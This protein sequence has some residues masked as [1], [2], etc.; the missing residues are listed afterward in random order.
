MASLD[1]IIVLMM[2]NNS[3]DRMLGALFAERADGGGIRGTARNHWN[4]DNSAAPAQRYYMAPTKAHLVKPDPGHELLNVLNQ[5]EGPCKHFVDDFVGLYPSST[6]QQRQEIMSYYDDG[7]LPVLHKFAKNFTVCDRWFSSMPGPTWPNRVF[8]HT[9]TS[10]GYTNNGL[11]NN[12]DQTTVYEVLDNLGITWKI[13]HGAADISQTAVLRHSPFTFAMKHFFDDAKKP[14]NTFPQYCFI[15]PHFGT[16]FKNAQNDQ[17]PLSDVYRGEQ[18][19]QAVYDAIRANDPL[20]QRTLLIVT[21]DEH[22]G[23]YDHVFPPPAVAP[24]NY[25]VVPPVSPPSRFTFQQLGVRVPTI[26]I[27]PWLDQGVLSETFDHTTILKFISEK[28]S[29]GNYLGNRVASNSSNSFSKY[30]RKSPRPVPKFSIPRLP[31]FLPAPDPNELTEYQESLIELGVVLASRIED[32]RVRLPLLKTPL[33]GTPQVRALRAIEQFQAFQLEL[34]RRPSSKR[35]LKETKGSP[36]G[37]APDQ[38][39]LKSSKRKVS[40]KRKGSKKKA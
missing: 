7:D 15:E 21:Y 38:S 30:I 11:G 37:T 5:M 10:K 29:L 35:K 28:W 36:K 22:G 1:H 24:D 16:V 2:E 26:L 23:F 6:L 27:S 25:P 17:H 18:L 31:D 14:E 20:W 40:K 34:A 4:D 8:A 13:Y 12:W 3:F 33:D 9:G 32:E 39:G 19:I